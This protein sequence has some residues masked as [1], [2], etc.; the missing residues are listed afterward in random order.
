MNKL[1]DVVQIKGLVLLF[2]KFE[3][4]DWLA[5]TMSRTELPIYSNSFCFIGEFLF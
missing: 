5:L 1:T 3:I 2:H 4:L